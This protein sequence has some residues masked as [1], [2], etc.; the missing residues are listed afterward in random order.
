V[1]IWVAFVLGAIV[2]MLAMPGHVGTGNV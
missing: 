2:I 1:A